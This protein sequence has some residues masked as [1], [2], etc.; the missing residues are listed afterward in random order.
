MTQSEIKEQIRLAY[1]ELSVAESRGDYSACLDVER[2]INHLQSQLLPP[3]WEPSGYGD[4]TP[5][6]EEDF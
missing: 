3:P 1:L 5:M 4:P 2:E 6:G